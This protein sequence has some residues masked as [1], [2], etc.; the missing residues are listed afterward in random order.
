MRTLIEIEVKELDHPDKKLR[1]SKLIIEYDC[2]GI[3][4]RGE[5]ADGSTVFVQAR[6]DR[7]ASHDNPEPFRVVGEIRNPNGKVIVRTR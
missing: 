1:L 3:A 5:A 7:A 6:S 4:F 2:D